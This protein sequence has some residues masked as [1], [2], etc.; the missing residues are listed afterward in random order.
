VDHG[1]AFDIAAKCIANAQSLEE[2]I[3]R[4]VRLSEGKI[5]FDS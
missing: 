3:K 4:A 5:L 2:A 1:T